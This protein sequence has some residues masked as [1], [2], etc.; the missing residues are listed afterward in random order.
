[1]NGQQT[2]QD[3]C[4]RQNCLLVLTH[5]ILNDMIKVKA[6]VADIALVTLELH[7]TQMSALAKW[8]FTELAAKVRCVCVCVC[9]CVCNIFYFNVVIIAG[10]QFV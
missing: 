10:Q 3:C 7:D 2:Q 6:P 4:V 5:L 9:V 1:M 8:F